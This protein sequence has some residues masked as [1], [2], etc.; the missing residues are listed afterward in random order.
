MKYWKGMMNWPIDPD[1]TCQTCG[2]KFAEA[3]IVGTILGTGLT[4]GLVHGECRCNICHT[5]YHMRDEDRV[6]IRPTCW[7]KEE[8]KA[9]A[10][11]G[12][13]MFG[14]PIDEFTDEQ[15]AKAQEAT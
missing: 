11:A 7:L 1:V 8:Y 6:L 4:W 10:K 5:H 13:E 3:G 2:K 15:W 9:A 12:W 14:V